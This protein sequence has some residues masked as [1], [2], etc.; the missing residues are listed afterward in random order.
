MSSWSFIFGC[1]ASAITVK[2]GPGASGSG[3]AEIMGYLNGVNMPKLIGLETLIVKVFGVAIAISAQAAI[4][5]EGPLVHIG[6]LV[7][8]FVAY[9]IPFEFLKKFRNDKD[10][11][12]FAVYGIAAGV[13]AAFSAPIGGTLFAYE[14]SRPST[15]WTFGMIWRTFFTSA[16]STYTIS[17][18]EHIWRKYIIKAEEEQELSFYL[19]TEGSEK[20]G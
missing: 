18:Y 6:T 3:I 9:Y 20:F 8:M 7:G 12:E 11:R 5:K 14:L 15:F 13:S 17:L 19:S 1:F 10:K 2:F 4:G 16:V